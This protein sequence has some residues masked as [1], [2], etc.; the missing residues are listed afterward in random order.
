MARTSL[1]VTAVGL[2]LVA[3]FCAGR[4]SVSRRSVEST[5]PGAPASKLEAMAG[6]ASGP[7]GAFDLARAFG[8]TLPEPGATPE[9]LA[10]EPM[11]AAE[12]IPL[13]TE[14]GEGATKPMAVAEGE[15]PVPHRALRPSYGAPRIVDEF[16]GEI[17]LFGMRLKARRAVRLNEFGD[18]VKDGPAVAWYPSGQLAGEM[19][20]V[21]DLP[22]GMQRVWHPN[23]KKKLLG[24]WNEGFAAGR[25]TEWHENGRKSADG[26]YAGGLEE[27]VWSRWDERGTLVEQVEFRAGQPMAGRPAGRW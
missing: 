24:Q 27:G 7:E 20:F 23:G 2:L 5:P 19:E 4:F 10:S 6:P 18:W 14:A 16:E 22:H 9:E 11:R 15:R 12:A 13:E 3:A 26:L 8:A 1:S 21:D 17:E 25:W